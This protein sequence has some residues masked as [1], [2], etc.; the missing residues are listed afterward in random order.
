V[1]T[2]YDWSVFKNL[3]RYNQVLFFCFF[4]LG[5]DCMNFFLKYILWIPANHNILPCRLFLWAFSSIACA[6]EYYEFITNRNCKRVGPFIWMASLALGVEFSIAI[7]FGST[8]FVEPFPWYV[9]AMWTVIGS[10]L[11]A[12]Q[13][14]SFINQMKSRKTES[15]QKPYD[16]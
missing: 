1:W 5:V 10:L 3:N 8:M 2:R 12:G 15:I 9:K 16:L 11:T 6:K 13:I 4:T 14:Y 7:K